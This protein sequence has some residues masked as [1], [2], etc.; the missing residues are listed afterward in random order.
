MHPNQVV[1]T[2][3][4]NQGTYLDHENLTNY[5]RGNKTKKT[6]ADANTPKEGI[7]TFG[8]EPKNGFASSDNHP[9]PA[10]H[11]AVEFNSDAECT[12]NYN[13]ESV[14]NRR[15]VMLMQYPTQTELMMKMEEDPRLTGSFWNWITRWNTS[16]RNSRWSKNR[17]QCRI[18][19]CS[20]W[21]VQGCRL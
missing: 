3:I 5:N 13:Q 8:V 4:S 2:W 10:N 12:D 16:W 9:T 1:A 7:E 21:E 6:L 14:A 15:H 20:V 18:R 19:C 11:L 17:C